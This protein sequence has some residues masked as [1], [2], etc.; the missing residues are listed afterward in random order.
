MS[1]RD[2]QLN[3]LVLSIFNTNCVECLEVDCSRWNRGKRAMSA[4]RGVRN[5][6]GH[7]VWVLPF[8]QRHAKPGAFH[9]RILQ[10]MYRPIA[11][12]QPQ[13][14]DWRR[15][16]SIGL[17]VPPFY[18]KWGA[19]DVCNAIKQCLTSLRDMEDNPLLASR[20][21]LWEFPIRKGHDREVAVG[22]VATVPVAG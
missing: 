15:W 16:D 20:L 22:F 7:N 10:P 8:S 11:L 17:A 18:P 3:K 13:C 1:N 19:L 14:P 4:M 9:I 2:S 21:G 12:W 5:W 6:G